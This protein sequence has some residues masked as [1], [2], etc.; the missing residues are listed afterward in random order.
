[1]RER[2]VCS[3]IDSLATSKSFDPLAARNVLR[4]M[5]EELNVHMQDDAEDLF[6]L[7]SRRCTAEDGIGRAIARICY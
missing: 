2:Q 4:F 3:V 1:M 5:N 7:L 6:P